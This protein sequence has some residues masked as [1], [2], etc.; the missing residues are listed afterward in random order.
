MDGRYNGPA[1]PEKWGCAAAAVVGV[2]LF[3]FLLLSDALGDCEPSPTCHHGFMRMVLAP[4]VVAI[5][6]LFLAT[7]AIVRRW[8]SD[9]S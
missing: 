1:A 3:L 7:R 2:P 5:T 4:S 6:L 9:G 8:K